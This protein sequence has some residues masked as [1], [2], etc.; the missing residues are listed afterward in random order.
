[1][2]TIGREA[3]PD[4]REL[5]EAIFA[6]LQALEVGQPLDRAEL[7]A[8]YPR[9]AAELE[10]FLA[11]R[12]RLEGLARPLRQAAQAELPPTGS[13][14]SSLVPELVEG[15]LG[16]FRIRGEIG[17]GGM[18]VVYEAEQISLD[19]RV[20]LKVLPF[21]ATLDPKQ[22]QRF[23]NEAQAAAHLQHQN[24][25]PV[26][27]VGCER[28]VHYYAMQ[29]VEGHSLAT[30]IAELRRQAGRAADESEPGGGAAP[31][32]TTPAGVLATEHSTGGR[33]FFASVAR[34]GVQA[35]EGLE[36]A[37]QLGV[38]HRDIKPANLLLDRRGN[39]WI[40]DFGLAHCQGSAG[41]TVT[42]DM[43]GTLRYMSPE[44][45]LGQHGLLD[46]RT[47]IYALGATLYELLTLQPVFDG[48]NREELLRQITGAEP[49]PP[50]RW[51]KAIPADLETIVLKALAKHPAERYATAQE[52]ADDLQRFLDD[53]PIRARR[54]TLVQRG[55]KWGRRHQAVV[56]SAAIV[57]TLALCLGV[58]S[59]LWITLDHA[60]RRA[61]QLTQDREQG[62]RAE[63]EL[64]LVR[65]LREK[66]PMAPPAV[67]RSLLT[68]ALAAAQRADGLLA[69]RGPDD[70]QRQ[71]AAAL[72]AELQGEERDRRMLAQLEE[73]ALS[74][75]AVRDEDPRQ[76]DGFFRAFAAAFQDY[77]VDVE[78]LPDEQAARR[79]RGRPIRVELAAALDSWARLERQRDGDRGTRLQ[80]LAC[81]VDPDEWR[82]R[83]RAAQ[84]ASDR[85]LLTELA[86]SDRATDLPPESL[87]LLC[88]SLIRVE[89][90]LAA[91]ALLRRARWSY[92]ADFWIHQHLGELATALAPPQ[93]DEAIECYR[94]AVALRANPIS[95][96]HLGNV[97]RYKKAHAEALLAY[98]WAIKLKPDFGRPH[99]ERGLLL[100]ALGRYQEALASL[101]KS[102]ELTPGDWRNHDDLGEALL[103]MDQP[104]EAIRHFE[105][106]IKLAADHPR[107]YAG[108][109]KACY[110]A[111]QP[112]RAEEVLRKAVTLKPY[113]RGVRRQDVRAEAYFQLGTVLDQ[114]PG[115]QDE[116]LDCYDKAIALYPE[117][118][119]AHSNRSTVLL[120]R[121]Q[122]KEALATQEA[123]ALYVEAVAAARKA[124]VYEPDSPASYAN[125]GNA[126]R[127]LN[128][129]DQAIEA[130]HQSVLRLKQNP[131]SDPKHFRTKQDAGVYFNLGTALQ[132]RGRWKESV[133]ALREAVQRVP[134]NG[135]YLSDLGTSLFGDGQLEEAKS[136]LKEAIQKDP[137]LPRA[138]E[139]LGEIHLREHRPEQ[140]AACFQ[141]AIQ[142]APEWPLVHCNLGAAL[143]AQGKSEKAIAAF[144]EALRRKPD[145]AI[146]HYNLGNE[147]VRLGRL[148]DA[149]AC[150]REAIKHDPTDVRPRTNLGNVLRLQGKTEQALAAYYTALTVAPDAYA[151]QHIFL[152]QYRAGRLD[153]AIDAG[154]KDVALR[155]GRAESQCNLGLALRDRGEFDEALKHLRRGHELGQKVEGWD[156]PSGEWLAGCENLA[157]L[158]RKLAAIGRGEAEPADD[159]ERVSL[160]RM[161][162]RDKQLHAT[163]A[164][165]WK[166]AFAARPKIGDNLPA[167]DRSTAACA[168]A[169]AGCGQGA[170][171]GK[172]TEEDRA[173]WRKQAL[174]WLKADLAL[175]AKL[176]EH[177]SPKERGLATQRLSLWRQDA[178]LAGVRA[179]DALARLPEVERRSW[180]QFWDE[181]EALVRRTA[182][183]KK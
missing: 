58:G 49:R 135:D 4:D 86:A 146:A 94:V 89:E 2:H 27:A 166:H 82:N 87:D 163:A 18:G 32:E 78:V 81:A 14:P 42:G 7:E 8:R 33:A 158:D 116:A 131:R 44:Q 71:E 66:A 119:V 149:I 65:K 59:W 122:Q 147:M 92:P 137:N 159:T 141:K 60:A 172:L 177:D 155:P 118:G 37:H 64:E 183:T 80:A 130:Y 111:G 175:C 93:T 41:L 150:Y 173:G 145:F 180:Q 115:R 138:H 23:K 154:R 13:A 110:F 36:H 106:A 38:V 24:I 157:M 69:Q 48:R 170:D 153:E 117:Y 176:L 63:A 162:H 3:T 6:C 45:A 20:A 88:M 84:V 76:L 11:D 43:I 161:A 1:M 55:R 121:G 68:E 108:L 101:E 72:V 61:D 26:Y 5:G 67:G 167:G 16:D 22:L 105:K 34:L 168:A 164:Q 136:L 160:A 12:A 73:V 125:L 28:G 85:K 104:K 96:L 165:L 83:V 142:L 46:Q 178:R 99:A 102:V 174:D 127:V 129:L 19:R 62:A 109:G 75:T 51:N 143:S 100:V 35:A 139:T 70:P 140:A 74:M 15:M 103:M 77:G 98:D 47:D 144:Q 128:Q 120:A 151:Y 179:A 97:Y 114:Q 29:L 90:K 57:A 124:I 52:M 39:L 152:I 79:L 17:R 25:V 169:Q 126:L 95:Y 21:A 56:W 31:A 50:R 148:D 9:F 132:A 107:P 10:E 123:R 113:R 91:A 133:A 134:D 30:L 156:Y 181:V 53:E 182:D 40:T 54:P 171:A 112:D